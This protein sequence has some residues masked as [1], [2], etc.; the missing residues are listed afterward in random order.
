MDTMQHI[1][2]FVEELR[3]QEKSPN[4]TLSY[5]YDLVL[6]SRWLE[7]T[8]G[9]PFQADRVT[10]T[11]L[12][13]YRAYLLTVE[14]RSPATINRR[15]ASL[16]TFFQW[17]RAEGLCRELPTDQVKGI[18]SSPRAPKSLPKKDVDRLIREVEQ[19]GNKRDAA[20]LQLLRHTGIR[21]GELV[22]LRLSD[23]TLTERKGQLVVRSGKG[24]KYRVVPLNADARKAL[25]DYLAIRPKHTSDALFLGRR[26]ERLSPRAVEKT[27]LKYAHQARLDEVTPH[28]LRHTFGKSALDAGVDLVTVSRLMG[29]ER[30]E[31]TA[32]Y[33][34]P[35]AQDLEQ[36]VEKLEADYIDGKGVKA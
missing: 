1:E 18:Q 27:V 6:F 12:R 13:E 25:N 20:L 35:S 30:L 22:A 19:S 17:A 23:V 33:T 10:P 14:Q 5:R 24:S 21:V 3:R 4:T 8:H 34:T 7:A 2:S 29:H 31:T 26:S 36:A 16:R 32:I 15:L 28:T 9:E 11:D